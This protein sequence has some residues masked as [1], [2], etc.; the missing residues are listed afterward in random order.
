MVII[1][2]VLAI[3]VAT[4]IVIILI[5]LW[6]KGFLKRSELSV[7]LILSCPEEIGSYCLKL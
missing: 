4:G 3:L 6:R 1:G 5:V 2:A 7:I